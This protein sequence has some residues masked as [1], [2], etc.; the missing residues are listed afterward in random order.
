MARFSRFHSVS[1]QTRMT[2]MN[3]PRAV[4]SLLALPKDYE[5]WPQTRLARLNQLN[6]VS[7]SPSLAKL[8]NMLCFDGFKG[9]VNC[10]QNISIKPNWFSGLTWSSSLGCWLV[11]VGLFFYIYFFYLVSLGAS[12]YSGCESILNK[13]RL[14]N[15]LRLEYV[16]LYSRKGWESSW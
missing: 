1:W 5:A 3:R 6:V 13:L 8:I 2:I 7:W 4:S 11:L 9:F 10:W 14:I 12:I 16:R 15:H